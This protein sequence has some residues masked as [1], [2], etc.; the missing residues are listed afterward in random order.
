MQDDKYTPASAVPS[1]IPGLC[2]KARLILEQRNT[3]PNPNRTVLSWF[4]SRKHSGVC[5]QLIGDRETLGPGRGR[6][7]HVYV[8][9]V[10]QGLLRV[11]TALS[12]AVAHNF[13]SALQPPHTPVTLLV[14]T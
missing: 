1:E 6:E 7:F 5:E 11:F 13:S 10:T 14:S 9:S 2:W 12:R 8:L 3:L 4:P